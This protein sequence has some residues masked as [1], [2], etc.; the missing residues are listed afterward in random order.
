MKITP[1]K[2]TV[3]EPPYRPY[4]TDVGGRTVQQWAKR[5][6]RLYVLAGTGVDVA[7]PPIHYGRPTSTFTSGSVLQL[8][9]CDVSGTDIV[10]AAYY[11]VYLNRDQSSTDLDTVDINEDASNET[12]GCSFDDT[13]MFMF[14]IADRKSVV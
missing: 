13:T 8:K 14:A 3:T 5:S 11:D 12:T 10:P 4:T 1:P 7:V 2:N 9:A 6:T